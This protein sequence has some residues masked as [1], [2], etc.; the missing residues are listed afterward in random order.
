MTTKQS[1]HVLND[2]VIA[3]GYCVGCGACAVP[4][5]SPFKIVM[6]EHGQYQSSVKDNSV[7]AKTQNDYVKLCPFGSGAPNEDEIGKQ[8]FSGS[9]DYNSQVGYYDGVFAGHVIEGDFRKQGSSGGMGTWLLNELLSKDLVDYVIHVKSESAAK[10]LHNIP[11]KYHISETMEQTQQGGKSRYYPVELS[12]VLKIVR[13]TPGRYVVVGLPCFVKSIR[14][15][16]HQ[17]PI[18]SE[19]IKYCVGLVCGHLKSAHYALSLGWQMGLAPHE[20][21]AID[22][23]VKDPSQP[24][25]RYSTYVKGS[26]AEKLMLTNKLFGVDWGAGA[27][28]YKACD[29]CDD[30][31]AETADVVVG[32]AWLPEYVKDSDGT[33]VVVTRNQ[34]ILR[35]ITDARTERRLKMDDLEVDRAAQSQD[36]GLRHR[37]IGIADRLRFEAEAGRWAPNKRAIIA[38]HVK[39][40]IDVERQRLRVKM[41]DLS[42]KTFKLALD[43]SDIKIYIRSVAPVYSKYRELGMPLKS[44]L[45]LRLKVV[46]LGVLKALGYERK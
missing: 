44:R 46:V 22:F 8:R 4:T 28:K 32:D 36:A 23:R 15:L 40:E 13:N 5:R 7:L 42:H 10:H 30:V 11:F 24:A 41:R 29:F 34:D 39:Q 14:L 37:K 35:L 3:N 33:N 2:T 26:T 25:N 17:D 1:H 12:E 9:C 31:F 16:Q 45:K 27:F 6:D 21:E 18:F 38:N 43:R 19:R 20:L